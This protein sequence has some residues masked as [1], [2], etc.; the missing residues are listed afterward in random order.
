M[1][2]RRA[3]QF[4][5]LRTEG[6][7][8]P[9]GLLGRV[10]AGDATLPGLTPD[11]YHLAAGERFG[12][13]INRAWLRLVGAWAGFRDT[14]AKLP[15]ADLAQGM[16]RERWLLILFS[17][18]GYGR[19][20]PARAIEADGQ[21]FPVS[22]EWGAT[23]IHLVGARVPL[24]R[25]SAGVPGAARSS[26]HSLVQELLNRDPDRLWGFVSNGLRLRLLRDNLSLTRQAYV[27]FDLQ[28]M[29]DG[30]V[31]SDFVVLWLLAH[32]SRVEAGRPEDCWLER[33]SIEARTQGTRALDHLRDGVEAAIV[34]LGNGFL[35]HPA[36][37]PLRTALQDGQLESRAYY[38]Q[39][40]RVV[41][42]LLF[43]LVA[44]ERDLLLLPEADA[45]T[46]RRYANYYSASRLRELAERRRGTRHTDLWTQ[47]QLVVRFLGSADG[48]PA[49]GLPALGSFLFSSAATAALNSCALANTD[50]LAALRALSGRED[51]RAGYRQ[52][53]D[54]RNLGVEELG[55]VYESLLELHPEVNVPAAR[56]NLRLGGSERRATGSH[57]TPPAILKRVLD[58]ALQPAIARALAAADP[59][60]ALL[61]LRVLDPACGSG[62]FLIAA[63]HRIARAVATVRTGEPEATPLEVRH[64]LREVVARCLYGVD[65]NPMA[66]ELCRVALWLETLQP[67]KPLSF[68]DH[69]IR[70]GDS[71]LGVPL[72]PT[73]ARNRAAVDAHR[74]ALEDRIGECSAAL[75]KLSALDPDNARLTHEVSALKRELATASTTRGRTPSPTPPSGRP[76]RTT[77]IRQEGSRL[78][79]AGVD[80]PPSFAW[81]RR[82]RSY[83]LT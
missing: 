16:T 41:Y 37:G 9:A 35:A 8:L 80:G 28:A 6:G 33:W 53:F 82:W 50:L 5:T 74:K 4:T 47:V 40:L 30:E 64:A 24:D 42:R 22:H 3:E 79:T 32:Q 69:H 54:Y 14:L 13:V 25:R 78:R 83:Q 38:R 55:S 17:E 81:L 51:Q 70:A 75:R 44:E 68:L 76:P 12:E 19:L 66:V 39:L 7:L 34:A 29:M 49:L 71:L 46:R 73:V 20:Q 1:S 18:L 27:E 52:R 21:P 23:P 56:F 15:D 48:C 67:G 61:D 57:Y 60:A 77:G 59:E 62:H 31:Y 63:A 26:P 72:G 2:T 10:A 11:A 43:L 36:N 58:F 65:V 45:E